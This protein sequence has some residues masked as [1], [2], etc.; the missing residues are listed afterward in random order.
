MT[1]LQRRIYRAVIRLHPASF[2]NEFGREMALDFEDAVRDCGFTPLLGDAMLSLARQWKVRA[3]EGPEPDPIRSRPPATPSSPASTSPSTRERPSPHTIS[4]APRSLL[5]AAADDW[6]RRQRS[7]PTRHCRRS[8]RPRQPRWRHRHRPQRPT[9]GH[10]PRTPRVARRRPL[11]HRARRWRRTLP[12]QNLSRP[13]TG[14]R[15]SRVWSPRVRRSK[16]AAHHAGP[17]SGPADRDQHHRLAHID[18]SAP[19]FGSGAQGSSGC[20][21]PA[22]HRRVRRVR[23]GTDRYP[24]FRV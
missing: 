12:R 5:P 13:G 7:Q 17:R 21:R 6:P 15:A 20:V 14:S 4:L 16:G 10:Q 23:A 22:R 3:L 9:P 2:R 19:Q 18:V 11:S 1:T 24:I 8:K